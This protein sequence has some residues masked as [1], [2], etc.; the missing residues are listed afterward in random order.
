MEKESLYLTT[1][2]YA[3][4]AMEYL[5]NLTTFELSQA[6]DYPGSSYSA[7]PLVLQVW[8]YL[9]LSKLWKRRQDKGKCNERQVCAY[10]WATSC[11]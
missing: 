4:Y 10:A 3:N 8:I 1:N 2:P 6:V 9:F 11:G 5:Q 7:Q